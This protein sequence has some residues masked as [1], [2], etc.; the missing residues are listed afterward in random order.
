MKK[1]IEWIINLLTKILSVFVPKRFRHLLTYETVSYLFFGGL[2]TIVGL[3]TF[4]LF[5]F[6]GM[7]VLVAGAFSRALAIIFAF[8]TNKPFVFESPSWRPGVLVPEAVKF[9]ASRGLTSV[10][11][12]LVLALLVDILG[13]SAMVVQLFTMVVIQVI[14]NYVL[15]K[16]VVFAKGSRGN[17]SR[18]IGE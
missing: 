18:E 14:G 12:I 10:V 2:T 7:S 17:I 8:V 15:S 3:G 4:A 16:W 9:G 6:Y 5:Y 1:I 11:E 13:L